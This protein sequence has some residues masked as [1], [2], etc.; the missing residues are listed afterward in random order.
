MTPHRYYLG[1]VLAL[2]LLSTT[3]C[4]TTG[5]EAPDLTLVDLQLDN[6]T[7]LESSGTVVL[8]LANS[9]PDPLRI[10]GLAFDLELDG[11]RIGQALSPEAV[12][13]PRLSTATVEAQ[14]NVNHLAVLSLLQGAL[15]TE[16]VRYAL[17]GK[18][19]VLTD[20]G[21]RTLRIEKSG[22]FDFE[23]AVPE[24]LDLDDVNIRIET[25]DDDD[26]EGD[27]DDE[28]RD[29]GSGGSGGSGTSPRTSPANSQP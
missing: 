27:G 2:V 3:G 23:G 26:E 17:S 21:R 6:V 20:Y 19:Y 22:L 13:V 4:A 5:L 14:L 8:R 11:R 29:G 1:L 12:E 10:D 25:G 15:E 9:N 24:D 18:V 16:Q 7:V 28:G